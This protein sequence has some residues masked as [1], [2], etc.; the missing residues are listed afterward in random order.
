MPSSV[1]VEYMA[2]Y[3]MDPWGEDRADLRMGI[4]AATVAAPHT[5]QRLSPSD[6]IPKFQPAEQKSTADLELLLMQFAN[7]H[8]AKIEATAN[9]KRN[10]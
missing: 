1:F 8:N 2:A 6:F 7:A 10:R 3:Q 9:G 5:K 4:L